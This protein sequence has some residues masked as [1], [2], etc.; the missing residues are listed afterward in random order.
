MEKKTLVKTLTQNYLLIRDVNDFHKY[1]FLQVQSPQN[2]LN[3]T[4]IKN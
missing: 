4:E 3:S 1:I 2:Y